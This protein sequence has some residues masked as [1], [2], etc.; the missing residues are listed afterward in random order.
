M[1]QQGLRARAG[2]SLALFAT[3]V[4]AVAGCVAAVGY[5]QAAHL[6]IGSAGALLLLSCAGLAAQ[7]ASSIRARRHDLALA[8]LRGR[9]G[10][11]LQRAA[12]TEP[13][14]ILLVAAVVGA[15]LGGIVAA[16]AVDRWVDGS[17]AFTMTRDEW[18]AAGVV[19]AVSLV[20]VA[21]VS[22]RTTTEPLS[23]KLD[24]L[25]RPR[26]A[27]TAGLFLSLLV[28]IGAVV[29]IYQARQLGVRRADWVSFV[30]PALVGLAA[31]QIGIWCVALVSQL[32]LR[33]R[34]LNGRLGWFL[35]VRRLTRR[36]DSVALIRIVVAAVVVAGV[37]ASAWVGSGAWRDQMARVQTGGPVAYVVPGG[38]LQAY[39]AAREADPEGQW[40][41]AMSAGPDDANGSRRDVFV[42]AP[43]WERVVGS[44]YADTPVASISG[45]VGKLAPTENVHPAHGG[46]FT[47]TFTK[48]S[49]DHA[50]PAHELR[51]HPGRTQA[52]GYASLQLTVSYVDSHGDGQVLQVPANPL[53]RPV[54][55]GPGTLAYSAVAPGCLRACAVQQVSVRGLSGDGAY[56]VK[57]I[58]FG[59]LHL[60]PQHVGLLPPD[61]TELLRTALTTAGLD[62]TL[63]DPYTSH[64]LLEWQRGAMSAALVTPGVVLD[65]VG[66]QPQADGP[67]GD[68]RPIRIAATVPALPLLG[69]S[70]L[71]LDLGTAL[72]G[73]GGQIP[74]SHTVV[75]ARA[76]TPAT[77][78]QKLTA[79]GALGATVTVGHTL[80]EIERGRTAR[81]TPLY[82][83]IAVF[84]LLIAAINVVS[85]ISEQRPERR[86]E[87]ASLR[88][89]GIDVADV[90]GSYRGEARA[91]GAAV[92]VVA[93]VAVWIACRALLG[94]LPLVAPGE[95]GLP[96]D[97]T[98]RLGLVAALAA[99]AGGYVALVVFL[100]F[101][102]IGHSARPSMLR[103]EDR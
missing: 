49:V 35:I 102:L 80:A 52:I 18:A 97:A 88:L 95:F 100:G 85:S 32:A 59:D 99:L 30:S 63:M 75:V 61:N 78:V 41:M 25:G 90:D 57:G 73:A 36:A 71:L 54:P 22:W 38:G 4:L 10:L 84:G 89:V 7:G 46:R 62:L 83:L 27:T 12:L 96:F 42:D 68:P 29:S 31:G 21:L 6:P 28:L 3:G 5:S 9:H 86:S 11:R 92:T 72:R 2:Q 101:R 91:L 44:F 50:W 81:A 74:D 82:S 55:T 26:P 98:P 58:S 37:A 76:D 69:R 56:R 103:A 8:Q 47:V 66:G 14:A 15:A 67:D 1:T 45:E 39:V 77:V 23:A 13:S 93:A 43:R 64:P 34:R 16:A 24:H 79:T 65:K 20:V 70:G 19:L 51:R 53:H 48:R 87:A 40:L 60:F 33:S 94:V 17:V